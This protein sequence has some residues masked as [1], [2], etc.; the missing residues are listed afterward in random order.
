M[1]VSHLVTSLISKHLI[2]V[3]TCKAYYPHFQV[4]NTL[5]SFT[6]HLL[7][8]AHKKRDLAWRGG[9]WAHQQ[10]L[11]RAS[12]RV[13]SSTAPLCRLVT[14]ITNS[15]SSSGRVHKQGHTQVFACSCLWTG[16]DSYF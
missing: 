13:K 6:E 12:A 16:L 3:Q 2:C 15:F 9:R 8:P 7:C 14:D 10:F 1:L 4:L 5:Q 11:I